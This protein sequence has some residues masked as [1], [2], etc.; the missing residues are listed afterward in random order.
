MRAS[1]AR[2]TICCLLLSLVL[3]VGART[4]A[5]AQTCD[6]GRAPSTP[7]QA[8]E[9]AA[10]VFTGTALSVQSVR[11]T[12]DG[13]DYLRVRFR[14]SAAEKGAIDADPEVWTQ[15]PATGCGYPFQAGITYHLY[16]ARATDGRLMADTCLPVQTL[17]EAGNETEVAA[18]D[19]LRTSPVPI[20]VMLVVAALIGLIVW[21]TRSGTRL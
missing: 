17:S 21:T 19:A 4:P 20:T 5:A 8:F 18:Q 7:D 10:A 12:A 11:S 1:S 9:Q 13:H 3:L 6:C 15:S 16:V 14:V 2:Q